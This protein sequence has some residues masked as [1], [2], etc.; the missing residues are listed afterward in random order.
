MSH[1]FF[2]THSALFFLLGAMV[3]SASSCG[4]A[5]TATPSVPTNAAQALAT[6][7]PTFLPPTALPTT[8]PTPLPTSTPT[9]VPTST[10]IPPTATIPPAPAVPYDEAAD[11]RK[12]IAAAQ[13][14]AKIDKKH[15][16]LV[17][18]ANWCPDCVALS[19]IF[20]DPSVW[21]FLDANYHV[22]KV[23]IGNWKKN[24]DVNKDFGS[25]VNGYVPAAAILDWNGQIVTTAK[26][27]RIADARSSTK[28]EILDYL[29][30][31]APKKP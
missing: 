13:A 7:S 10:P 26:D 21:P 5:V 4:G 8:T 16:L 17:F 11:A 1:S 19:K 30:K 6:A 23:D 15:V 25:P 9:V 3:L 22:V 29:I 28:Q 27:K 14:Q 2:R 18:G 31:W 20:Y 12:D 24:M